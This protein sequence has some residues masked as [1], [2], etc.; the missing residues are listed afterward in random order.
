MKSRKKV[1]F[2]KKHYAQGMIEGIHHYKFIEKAK[3]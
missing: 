1:Y 3:K 2:A